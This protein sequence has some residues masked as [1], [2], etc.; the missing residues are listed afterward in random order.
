MQEPNPVDDRLLARPRC[1]ML[2]SEL[3]EW[4]FT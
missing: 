3:L 1:S 4:E 2:Q